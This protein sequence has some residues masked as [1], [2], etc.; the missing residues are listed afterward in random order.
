MNTYGYVQVIASITHCQLRA[1][2]DQMIYLSR[3]NN[4][5]FVEGK[6]KENLLSLPQRFKINIRFMRESIVRVA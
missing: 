2:P 3:R 6:H 1:K 4:R 5:L